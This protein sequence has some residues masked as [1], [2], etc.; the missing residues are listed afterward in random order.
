MKCKKLMSAALAGAMA[1]SLAVPAFAA[2]KDIAADGA[3]EIDITGTLQA[4]TVKVVIPDDAST[5]VILNPYGLEVTVGSDKAT[6]QVINKTV[7]MKNLTQCNV[8][9]SAAVTGTL[10]AAGGVTFATAPISTAAKAPTTKQVFMY[11]E[12]STST[13]G[14]TEPSWKAFGKTAAANQI[15]VAKTASAAKT[16]VV[17]AKSP[18]GSATA[19]ANGYAAFH[20]AGD[21][22]DQSTTAWAATDAVSV[23]VA[24]T[25]LPTGAEASAPVTAS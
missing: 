3:N 13:D 19:D 24:F 17:M 21:C 18:D 1:L 15:V 23:K 7:Y 25:F 16:M 9:V 4:P 12:M 20:L 11:F 2:D 5:S 22:A 8:Q 14:S 6:D 10:P